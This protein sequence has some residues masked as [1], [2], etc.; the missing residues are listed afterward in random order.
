MN[1][2]PIPALSHSIDSIKEPDFQ[3]Q[4]FENLLTK[5]LLSEKLGLSQSY[6][7]LLMKDEGLPHLKIGRAV[8]FRISEVAVWLQKRS[9]PC[10]RNKKS[11]STQKTIRESRVST[12]RS[13]MRRESVVFGC[14]TKKPTSIACRLWAN[15][16]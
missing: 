4:V 8:R 1:K 13:Q 16:F 11:H 3:A 7:S 14:G 2:L 5:K 6:L 10:P 9:R 12:W 15:A